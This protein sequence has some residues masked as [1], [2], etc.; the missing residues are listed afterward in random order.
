MVESLAHWWT[1][2]PQ[3]LSH[4]QPINCILGWQL[5]W[6][7]ED[8][9]RLTHANRFDVKVTESPPTRSFSPYPR[10][11]ATTMC[12]IQIANFLVSLLC[13]L[14]FYFTLSPFLLSLSRLSF[15]FWWKPEESGNTLPFQL[16][17]LYFAISIY[18]VI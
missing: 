10:F 8:P 3:K 17:C 16:R 5:K 7:S 6:S 11:M 12:W 18:F 1:F 13:F 4:I 9:T 14:Q 15:W 2:M